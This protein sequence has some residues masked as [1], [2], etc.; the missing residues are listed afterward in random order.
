MDET[1]E[2][3]RAATDV[4]SEYMAG[5]LAETSIEEL[6]ELLEEVEDGPV[7]SAALSV[8][9]AHE[10]EEL[11]DAEIDELREALEAADPA[12]AGTWPED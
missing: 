3:M 2:L 7:A 8:V 11:S 4:V 1:A 12:L 5:D 6:A 9:D 10:D